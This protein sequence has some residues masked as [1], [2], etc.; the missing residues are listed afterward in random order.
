MVYCFKFFILLTLFN[1]ILSPEILSV[2]IL[3][4]DN[5]FVTFVVNLKVDKAF[6]PLS[7]KNT[8]THIKQC[9]KIKVTKWRNEC[10]Y[11]DW[12]KE[13]KN[14]KLANLAKNILSYKQNGA[15]IVALQEVEN[16][17]ILNEL[18][19]LLKPYGYK[20]ISLLESKDRRGIDTAFISK[21]EIRNP[22]LHYIKFSKKK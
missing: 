13:I 19:L 22:K 6:L 5:L 16:I 2:M 9:N 21:Y 18:F 1:L 20:N 12:N 4:V 10:L 14:A 3:N 7:V 17:Q 8:I 11:L 15:D